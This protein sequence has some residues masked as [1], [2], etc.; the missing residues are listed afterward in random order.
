[1]SA[2][3]LASAKVLLCASPSLSRCISILQCKVSAPSSLEDIGLGESSS[4][5]L[6]PSW[7]LAD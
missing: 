1:M 2:R 6:Q 4:H 3:D 5:R 7:V